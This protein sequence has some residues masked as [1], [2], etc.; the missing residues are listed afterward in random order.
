MRMTC[1]LIGQD[2]L[3]IH[4]AALLLER[5]HEIKWV[6]TP[7]ASIQSWCDEHHIP[8]VKAIAMLPKDSKQSV[9]YLFSIV[10]GTILTKNDLNIA[11]KA[12]INYHDSLLPKYAGVHATTWA[13][14]K[15]EQTHGITWHLINEGIDTGDIVYQGAFPLHADETALTLNLRCFE[16]AV[17]GFTEIVHQIEQECLTTSSQSAEH[18]SYFGLNH[19]LPDLGFINWG[20]ADAESIIRTC[21]ALHF[22]NYPNH[23]GVLKLYLNG[24]YLIVRDVVRAHL[25]SSKPS[26]FVLA[27]DAAGLT[28]STTTEPVTIKSLMTPDGKPVLLTNRAKDYNIEVNSPL[29]QI[30]TNFLVEHRTHYK[31]ALINEKYWLQKLTELTEHS[32]FSDRM[33]GQDKILHKLPPVPYPSASDAPYKPEVYLLASIMIYLYRI[34]NY[35]PFTLFWH[36]LQEDAA[37]LFSS[38]LP[39]SSEGLESVMPLN[40]ILV[41]MHEKLELLTKHSNHL[42]DVFARQPALTMAREDAKEYLITAGPTPAPNSLIHYKVSAD[43]RELIIHHRINPEFQG[44]T[45][46]PVIKHMPEHIQSILTV[47]HT[48]PELLVHQFSFLN[49]REHAE[50]LHWSVGEYR[51]LPSNSIIELFAQWVKFAPHKTA[52]LDGNA[53]I[54]YEHMWPYAKSIQEALKAQQPIAMPTDLSCADMINHMIDFIKSDSW[55]LNQKQMINYSFWL[56]QQIHCTDDSIWAIHP[57]TR[58]DIMITTMLTCLLAG[59]TLHFSSSDTTSEDYLYQLQQHK[60]THM[61]LS[62]KALTSLLEHP[63]QIPA[64]DDLKYIIFTEQINSN[65]PL[66]TRLGLSSTIQYWHHP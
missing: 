46:A 38:L 65:H 33:A 1:L 64:L 31:Q 59:G 12:S 42:S 37:S 47:L 36:N 17:K 45:L 26:G 18:R 6:V 29:P 50:L 2:N 39:I 16:E 4:C 21:R 3:L 57:S 56:A 14:L 13:I 20:T 15:G 28:V 8:W 30:D 5:N 44:G 25:S 23:V 52:L 34:N 62:P 48:E 35:E 55:H 51:A 60:C 66:N 41:L 24:S 58:P 61:T 43:A 22:G 53:S 49:E 32:F 11:R 54:S 40:Q 7:V 63:E 10:N 9:D 27:L 19:V